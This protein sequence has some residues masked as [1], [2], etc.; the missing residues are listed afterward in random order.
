MTLS[1][2]NVF[3][4]GCPGWR[5]LTAALVALP[6]SMTPVLA[7]EADRDW[8]FN[9]RPAAERDWPFDGSIGTAGTAGNAGGPQNDDLMAP[10]EGPTD[11]T[12]VGGET[13]PRGPI[14]IL[15]PGAANG[16]DTPSPE[17]PD[18][19]QPMPLFPA[20]PSSSG[21]DLPV[22]ALSARPGEAGTGIEM[23]SLGEVDEASVGLLDDRNGG[24]GAGMWAG[25][26]R[27]IV[28]RTLGNVPGPTTSPFAADLA[29]RF[30]LT[31]ARPPQ[32]ATGG[33]SLLAV[34]LE[35]LNEA[36]RSEDVVRLMERAGGA[37][38]SPAAAVEYA[39]GALGAGEA[40]GACSMLQALPVG[41]DPSADPVAAFALK[42]SLFCQVAGGEMIAANLTADLAREQGFGDQHFL[43]LAAAATDG[44]TLDARPP[45]Q[46]DQL[47]FRMMRLAERPLTGPGVAQLVPGLLVS[48]AGDPALDPEI[49]VA[50]AERAASLGLIDGDE[51]AA[52]YLSFPYTREDVA[53]IRVGREPASPYRRRA[54]FH[55]AILDER[56]P[57]G[58]AD[59]LSS[60]LFREL[61]GP[62][63]RA[64]LLAHQ[65][66]LA[67]VPPSS[68]LSAFAPLA[69]RA[70]IELG[71]RVR[72]E[73]WTAVL[74]K[75]P[76]Q[77]QRYREL[78]AIL[79][80][81]DPSARLLVA[82]DGPVPPHVEDAL[83]RLAQGGRARDFAAVEIVL[84]DA[85]G[86][87]MPAAVWDAV[88]TA[89]D[90]PGGEVPPLALMRRLRLAS[91]EGR[92]GET[93]LLILDAVADTGPGGIHPQSLGEMVAALK[94]VGLMDEARR[95]AAEAL[96]ARLNG[97]A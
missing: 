57:A 71:D 59:L 69:A 62:A 89:G 72:A 30:L 49:R 79:R 1:R 25:T 6:F 81:I 38:P 48:V 67:S 51:M 19:A 78:K 76:G 44:L 20:G 21:S 97:G 77:K 87:K 23:G 74:G 11:E 14:S 64:T 40:E 41:G 66:S 95:F 75:V 70:F 39:T 27:A 91:E 86:G 84:L 80:L 82:P 52:A 37:R 12:A 3:S 13:R 9:Q 88:L 35:R 58:R 73:M 53:G 4:Q 92:L 45:E 46:I 7:E 5:C 10:A 32:G 31:A 61:D 55:Q 65:G 24:L 47:T 93:V 63:H 15:P 43:S 94:R 50:A 90:L 28:E 96:M 83:D 56:V 29:R 22:R 85:L 26:D 17:G 68:V 36:G 33:V 34:R 42:L 54:L 18:D 8:P 2:V 16:G 60:L